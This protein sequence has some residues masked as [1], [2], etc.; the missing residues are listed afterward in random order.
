M[1]SG[2][3]PNL[4]VAQQQD[5]VTFWSERFK[6]HAMLLY[7]LLDP[8]RAN[9]LKQRA[10]QEFEYWTYQVDNPNPANLYL[11]LQSLSVLKH[12]IH[13]R[14]LSGQINLMLSS[15]DFQSLVQHMIIE[16]NYFIRLINGQMSPEEEL[17]FW[18]QE[19]AQ[20]TELAAHLL[21]PGQLQSK[22]LDLAHR[23]QMLANDPMSG[24]LLMTY[25]T[26]NQEAINLDNLIQQQHPD[27]IKQLMHIMIEH[28]IKEGLHG[29][30][31]IRQLL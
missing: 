6:D 29:E 26:S 17:A 2:L 3:P 30:Q 12:D 8:Q 25:H 14:S 13:N 22:T 16:L 5:D 24:P 20:H 21:P 18:T 28:E 27:A 19:S 9:D 4:A 23:L 1:D 15:N 10:Q 7:I 31:R 11:L